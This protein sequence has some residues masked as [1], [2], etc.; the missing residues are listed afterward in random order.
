MAVHHAKP[1]TIHRS[2]NPANPPH[3]PNP[4]LPAVPPGVQGLP[5]LPEVSDQQGLEETLGEGG[6]ATHEMADSVLS[7]CE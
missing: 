4:L 1:L 2:I 7:F 6:L 3:L 5:T